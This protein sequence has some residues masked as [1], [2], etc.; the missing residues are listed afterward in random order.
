MSAGHS[1]KAQQTSSNTSLR[2]NTMAAAQKSDSNLQPFL[3]KSNN[4]FAVFV[5]F[6][7]FF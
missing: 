4:L 6:Q 5:H 1:P 3:V 2:R 7:P